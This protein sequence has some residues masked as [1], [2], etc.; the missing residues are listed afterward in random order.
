MHSLRI[1]LDTNALLRCIS[2]RSEYGIILEKLYEKQF[3]LYVSNEILLE[4]EEKISDIF[5][6]ETAELLLSAFS[7]LETVK[8]SEIHYH[9]NLIWQDADDNKFCDCSFAA[10]A[11]FLVTNDKH[12]NVLRS[13]VFPNIN[14]IT[15]EEFKE[16]LLSKTV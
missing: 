9:L 6:K 5:S 2:R 10:N 11:H 1:V 7:L 13:V 12:F 15:L 8:K 14:I 16:V 3:E 4:H